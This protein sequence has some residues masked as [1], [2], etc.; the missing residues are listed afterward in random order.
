MKHTITNTWSEVSA[1]TFKQFQNRSGKDMVI[2]QASSTPTDDADCFK[3]QSGEMI[4]MFP[5]TGENVYAK[6]LASNEQGLL[7]SFD[8]SM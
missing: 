7:I 1:E 8:L 5:P 4:S 3:L 2:S 6:M